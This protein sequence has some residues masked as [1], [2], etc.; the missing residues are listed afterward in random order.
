MADTK[1]GFLQMQPS[2]CWAVC[3]PGRAPVEITSGEI[4]A[5]R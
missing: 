2:G 3:R 1:E 5:S 4:S